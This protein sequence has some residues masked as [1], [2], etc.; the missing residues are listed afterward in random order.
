MA[1]GPIDRLEIDANGLT[2]TAR[3]AGPLDGRRVL[4]LHGF[5]Q[6]SGSWRHVLSALGDEGYRAVA[7]DQRGYTEGAR[8]PEV[9]DYG[10]ECLVSDV[11]ALAD[12]MEMDTFDLVGHDWGGLLSWVVAARHP[13]RVR[14]L[15]VVSTPHPLALR[16]AIL[17]E[18]PG[19]AAR[20]GGMDAYYP[21]EVP[22]LL[23]LGVDGS[24]S[25]LR[26]LFADSGLDASHADEYL[27]AL[28]RP[29][30]LTAALHWYRAMEEADLAGLPQVRVPTLYVWSTGDAALGRPAAEASARYVAGPYTFEVLEGVSHWIPEMAPEE[31]ARLLVAHLAA[32]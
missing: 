19:Q 20:A 25:G 22:E 28:V 18:D 29:G 2:F 5:P 30:A 31:L 3:A 14:S 4:L 6:T 27:D 24:G 21:P 11:V 32:H 9:A 23:L 16:H 26:R 8:P 10:L 7:P 15:S 13:D 12:S 17:R 1:G